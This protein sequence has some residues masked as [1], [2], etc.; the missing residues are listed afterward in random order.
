MAIFHSKLLVYQRVLLGKC[1][2]DVASPFDGLR[3]ELCR[4]MGQQVPADLKAGAL[5][6]CTSKYWD[7]YETPLQNG[8]LIQ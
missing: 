3:E 5:K 6:S 2:D 8:M 7:S 4:H 1:H